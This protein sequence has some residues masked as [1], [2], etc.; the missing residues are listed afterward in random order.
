VRR[1]G[2]VAVDE[3][4]PG[5]RTLEIGAIVA[6]GAL[7]V[8]GATR[9]VVADVPG[10]EWLIAAAAIAGYAA[11][12]FLSGLAHWLF[13]TFGSPD[14]PVVG[15][16]FIRP[17]REHHDDPASITRHDFVETNGNNCLAALPILTVA[18][19][20]PITTR[21]AL[22][23]SGLLLFTSLAIVATNQIHKWA[24]EDD[25]GALI[26]TL[27][28]WHLILPAAHHRLHHEAPHTSN[29][30]IT[31]GWLNPL[32]AQIGFHRRLERII[33]RLMGGR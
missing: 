31:T 3:Y 7:A 20:I 6:A 11:A 26:R 28:R 25:P 8:V 5:H 15:R 13:D 30:C 23:G 14:T 4:T 1:S 2:R 16:G 27:Q 12:D 29:Y 9:L 21:A 22:F 10:R 24:H 18:A 17:F 33:Q 19:I 32:L